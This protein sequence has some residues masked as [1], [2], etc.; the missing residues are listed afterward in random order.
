MAG[1]ADFLDAKATQSG[2]AD[3]VG[4][5]KQAIQKHAKKI[6]LR[7]GLSYREW[8]KV[9]CAHIREEAAGRG[10][11]KHGE[12]TLQRIEESRQKTLSMQLDNMKELKQ[13]CMTEDVAVAFRKFGSKISSSFDNVGAKIIESIDS[14]YD[15]TVDEQLVYE[16]LNAARDS[17]ANTAKELGDS[18]ERDGGIGSA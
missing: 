11:D 8:L 17:I 7:A 14:K 6:G 5:S 2:F 13:L 4:V 10:G 15:I 1:L 12:L 9:Y 3:L 16:P 18:F